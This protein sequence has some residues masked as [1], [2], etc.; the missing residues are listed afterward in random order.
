MVKGNTL[1]TSVIVFLELYGNTENGFYFL[2]VKYIYRLQ[3][4]HWQTQSYLNVKTA[5]VEL[6]AW[7]RTTKRVRLF[8]S[9]DHWVRKTRVV[10]S[11]KCSTLVIE[12]CLNTHQITLT[13]HPRVSAKVNNENCMELIPIWVTPFQT[14]AKSRF[15]AKTVSSK[16]SKDY[17]KGPVYPQSNKWIPR[18]FVFQPWKLKKI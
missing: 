11:F 6:L 10:F 12:H 15:D 5:C 2:K 13:Y 17:H 16:H 18:A 7:I 8:R 9:L 1:T 14:Q 3:Y 4:M